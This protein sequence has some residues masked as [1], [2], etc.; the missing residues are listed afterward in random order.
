MSLLNPDSVLWTLA[1]VNDAVI[2]AKGLGNSQPQTHKLT[3][4]GPSERTA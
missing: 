3:T 4:I 2:T 1:T